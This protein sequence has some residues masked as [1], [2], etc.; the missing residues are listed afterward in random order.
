MNSFGSCC[1]LM[2]MAFWNDILDKVLDFVPINKW[3]QAMKNVLQALGAFAAFVFIL[4][5]LLV[6]ND[7]GFSQTARIGLIS[8]FLFVLVLTMV[9]VVILATRPGDPLFSPYERSLNR[10]RKFG[11]KQ[12][13]LT[14]ADVDS[15]AKHTSEM[16]LPSPPT[17]QERKQLPKGDQK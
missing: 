13:P 14:K 10:G 6:V 5:F 11:T 7:W 4:I 17:P 15:Q 2:P 1:I 16:G 9:I 12:R 8:A 3:V